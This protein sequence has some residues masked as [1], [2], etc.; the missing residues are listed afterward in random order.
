MDNFSSNNN[1]NFYWWFGCI[2]NRDDPLRLGRCKVRIVG[3]HTDDNEILATEDLPWAIPIGPSNSAGSSGVG[4]SP[5]GPV[6]GTWVV[7][8]FADGENAQHPMFFGTVGSIP[9]GLAS[10][11]CVEGEHTDSGD[12]SPESAPQTNTVNVSGIAGKDAEEYLEKVLDAAK[13][14]LIQK[15]AIMAQCNVE[16]GS[17]KFFREIWGPTGWQKKYEGRSDLGN[18][19]PGDGFKFRG[20]GYIQLT[21]RANYEK[22]GKYIQRDLTG[23]PELLEDP[24]GAGALAVV[25]FF[26]QGNGARIKNYADCDEVT[27]RVNG[28]GRLHLA[29]RKRWFEHYKKKYGVK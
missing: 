8:F 16:T 20:R 7:G 17:F 15:A 1:S 25:F 9:G 26:R 24:K 11:N 5:T 22:C 28:K 18:K 13:F 14:T 21:G 2:E 4:W 23:K 3:Y 12:G 27:L 10:A 6:E 19:F 29:D